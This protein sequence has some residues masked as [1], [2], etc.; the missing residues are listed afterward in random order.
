[1]IK[2]PQVK[3]KNYERKVAEILS[4]EFGTQVR[5]MPMSGAIGDDLSGDLRVIGDSPLKNC[6]FELKKRKKISFEK[7]YKKANDEANQFVLRKK[8][9]V[10][11]GID[12]GEDYAIVSL[13]DFINILKDAFSQT[14]WKGN[15]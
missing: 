9:V 8:T 10:I 11:V 2:H 5:R 12:N 7:W 14:K 13:K 15:Q 6:H 1:M 3:G 4:T